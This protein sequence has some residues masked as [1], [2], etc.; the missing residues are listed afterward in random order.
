MATTTTP[1]CDH[2][3]ILIIYVLITAQNDCVQDNDDHYQ[4]YNCVPDS[5]DKN[6]ICGDV[7]KRLAVAWH[8]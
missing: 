3:R 6:I 5:S 8:I 1:M 4:M 2:S 7:Q